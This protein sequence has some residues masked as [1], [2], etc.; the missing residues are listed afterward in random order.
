MSWHMKSDISSDNAATHE[1]GGGGSPVLRYEFVD[2]LALD[3]A[4][5]VV[6]VEVEDQQHCAVAADR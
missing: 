5:F 1:L 6:G 2:V 4:A 3:L